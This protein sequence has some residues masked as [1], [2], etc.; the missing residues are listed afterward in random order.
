M[1]AAVAIDYSEIVP[2]LE[3]I[4]PPARKRR[5]PRLR[6][7]AFVANNL[8]RDVAAYDALPR[9]L[10]PPKLPDVATAPRN[11]GLTELQKEMRSGA[12][13]RVRERLWAHQ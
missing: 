9:P 6:V 12:L 1:S 3:D 4:T 5:A 2:D 11:A 8:A 7:L 10:K 13:P